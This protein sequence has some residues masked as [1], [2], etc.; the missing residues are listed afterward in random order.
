MTMYL[1]RKKILFNANKD[2]HIFSHGLDVP[3]VTLE[4]GSNLNSTTIREGADVYFECNIKSN[5]WIY[6]VN[7]RQNVSFNFIIF[8]IN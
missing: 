3:V 6:K 4:L 8:I 2:F 5:P 7:W 1:I